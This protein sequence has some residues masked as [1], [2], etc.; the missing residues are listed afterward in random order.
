MKISICSFYTVSAIILALA[1]LISAC[2]SE[3]ILYAIFVLLCFLYFL[4]KPKI[5]CLPKSYSYLF[6]C[7][8]VY[9]I[10]NVIISPYTEGLIYTLIGIIYILLPLSLFVISYNLRFSFQQIL[11]Y[12]D[13]YIFFILCCVV[14][15]WISLI[16]GYGSEILFFGALCSL[17][18]QGI[19]LSV[20]AY[21]N[22]T[23]NRGK[24]KYIILLFIV[25]I[26]LSV[27]IKAIGGMLIVACC[28]VWF[29]N[30]YKL[31]KKIVIVSIVA[32]MGL[33]SVMM[34]DSIKN[35]IV[36]SISTYITPVGNT[37]VN[38]MA[39]RSA[40]Y[41]QAL[42]IANDFFP[43][44]SGPGTYG[45]IPVVMR[46]NQLY[47]DYNLNNIWGLSPTKT[48]NFIMDT[49]W[50]SVLGELGYVG[51]IMYIVLMVY[52]VLIYHKYRSKHFVENKNFSFLFY[53]VFISMIIESIALPLPQKFAFMFVYAGL[54][55]IICRY[56]VD[57]CLAKYVE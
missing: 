57:S 2:E 49:H 34:I 20:F 52:P 22:R 4:I 44:G 55:A 12:I 19:I 32:I 46:Y 14:F 18:N 23:N 42:H 54:N 30:K 37:D 53:T 33:C 10:A 51:M 31:S 35:K 39:A 28:Y 26:I 11:K 24:Y 38:D 25:Q 29:I 45:S 7:F 43:F 15:T 3:Y 8:V 27:Q 13:S 6:S 21:K 1:S 41:I 56:L 5:L 47:Y 50:S 16:L 17:C 36:S 48:P 40:L 9:L